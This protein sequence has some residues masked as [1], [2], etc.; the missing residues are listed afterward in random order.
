MLLTPPLVHKHS[1]VG[2]DMFQAGCEVEH[3]VYTPTALNTIRDGW[4]E[5]GGTERKVKT[6]TEGGHRGRRDL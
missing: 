6:C 3:T 4:L 2:W 1:A 5:R